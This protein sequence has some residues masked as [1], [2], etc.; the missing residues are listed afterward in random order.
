MT[1]AADEEEAVEDENEEETEQEL[2]TGG[3][4]S[5]EPILLQ[6]QCKCSNTWISVAF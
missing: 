5:A 4:Q 3:G 6:P 1:V 2:A